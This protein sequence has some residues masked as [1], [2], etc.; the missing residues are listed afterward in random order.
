MDLRCPVLIALL[1]ITVTVV[2][3]KN[4][5]SET[6]TQHRHEMKSH[7]RHETRTHHRHETKA[8]HRHFW[9]LSWLDIL[10]FFL[11]TIALLLAAG[12]GIGGGGLLIP[13]LIL[14]ARFSTR[15][16]VPL[17]NVTIFGGAISNF[18]INIQKRHPVA[19]RPLIDFDLMLVME[20]MTILGALVG[21]LLNIVLPGWVTCVCLVVL[22]GLTTHRTT[23]TGLKLYN[24]E[25]LAQ[26][27]EATGEVGT[28]LTDVNEHPSELTLL[29][30]SE[31][32]ANQEAVEEFLRLEARPLP[33][34]KM[35]L[36]VVVT[37][38]VLL[39]T[40]LRRAVVCGSIIYHMLTLLTIPVILI[41]TWIVRQ[42]LLADRE[43]R[44]ALH[45]PVCDGDIMWD[46]KS[47]LLYPLVCCVAGVCA[48][49]F[50]IGGGIVKGPLMLEMGVLP[51]V[52]SAT[53]AIMIL[54]TTSTAAAAYATAGT[55]RYDYAVPFCV[56]GL[57]ATAL[58]QVTTNAIVT[59][60]KRASFVV[61]LIAAVI[62]LSTVSM[63]T[64]SIIDLWHSREGVKSVCDAIA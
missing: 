59:A 7:H 58:G 10:T 2:D 43:Q 40:I 35:L 9:P 20:P 57:L 24:Q 26:A 31:S 41:A 30:P 17:S 44:L 42:R 34:E 61:F 22:L 8:H 38:L 64:E 15:D 23:K 27:R 37:G 39:L 29:Q 21:A 48:G 53:T 16:A 51:E 25:S 46:D 47:T 5:S 1:V 52:A 6:L 18:A 54:F 56:L 28:V 3:A 36:M 49:M 33:A 11:A 13:L 63:G 19:D 55:L 50:G 4:H 14:V 32:T 12:S 62:G 45:I 60:T